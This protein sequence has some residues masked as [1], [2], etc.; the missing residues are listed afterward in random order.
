MHLVR[1]IRADASRQVRKGRR[2]SGAVREKGDIQMEILQVKQIHKIYGE[3]ENKV[4]ALRDVSFSVE[5]GEFI[6]IVGTSGS[7]KSTLLNLIGGLDTPTQG[8]IIIRGHDIASLKRKELTIFRR[9]N[10]GFVFQDYSLMPVLNVY[11]NVALPVTF[12]RGK[13]VDHGYIRELLHELGL[14]EKRKRYPNELSGG[15]QQRVALARALAN[16]PA[17]ILADEPTG[18][19]DSGTTVEV[20]GLLKESSRKYNQTILM[21]THNEALAQACDRI[22]RIEDGKLYDRKEQPKQAGA[23]GTSGTAGKGGDRS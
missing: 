5:Q 21:V 7:G 10:I 15:Q 4:Y 14:W 9:R 17:L 3:K 12:D 20:M 1:C 13:Y 2:F 19:L 6:A 23:A 11:D 8:K 16:K 22:I 18:N